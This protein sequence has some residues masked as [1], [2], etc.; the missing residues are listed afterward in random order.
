MNDEVY[1]KHQ[2]DAL[3]KNATPL[4][5]FK[6]AERLNASVKGKLATVTVNVLHD[7]KGNG[8]SRRPPFVT[9]LEKNAPLRAALEQVPPEE[10]QD[11]E[12]IRCIYVD[13]DFGG[14]INVTLDTPVKT[15]LFTDFRGDKRPQHYIISLQKGGNPDTSHLGCV[16]V[17]VRIHSPTRP[18]ATGPHTRDRRTFIQYLKDDEVLGNALDGVIDEINSGRLGR[19]AGEIIAAKPV[20]VIK[21]TV[22]NASAKFKTNANLS[23]HVVVGHYYKITADVE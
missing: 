3:T 4:G 12:V 19:A 8:L 6:L 23:T 22:E 1:I 17:A 20:K 16:V 2:Y 5:L 14:N 13:P 21:V 11:A 9:H 10:L 7:S 15:N 18:Y